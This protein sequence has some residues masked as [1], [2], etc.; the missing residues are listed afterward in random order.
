M[1]DSNEEERLLQGV[2][3][4]NKIAEKLDDPDVN[5]TLGY[6]IKLIAKPDIPA[7]VATPLITK[8]QALSF[9]FKMK[10]KY[11]MLIGKGEPDAMMKK[12]MYISL[13]EETQELVQALKY[14]TRNY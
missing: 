5:E 9:E 3:E 4:V 11:Y 8:L 7:S 10:G 14:T 12:N 13:S 6:V 1:Q 2:F